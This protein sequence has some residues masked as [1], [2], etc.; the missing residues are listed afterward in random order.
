[1]IINIYT[2]A[3]TLLDKGSKSGVGVV[4]CLYGEVYKTVGVHIGKTDIVTAEI[5]A[6]LVGLKEA[7]EICEICEVTRIRICSDCMSAIDLVVGDSQAKS[8]S[9]QL[10]LE[11]I[12]EVCLKI[13][14]PI[15]FQWVKAHSGNQFNEMAD[16]LAYE[17]AH[18]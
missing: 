17:H 16:Q 13:E 6:I 15:D 8:Q 18:N 10:A 5:V 7:K 4:I 2:D 3:S 9:V 1:M 11:S 12:D 14:P